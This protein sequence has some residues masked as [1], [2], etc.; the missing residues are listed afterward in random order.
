MFL[1]LPELSLSL[2]PQIPLR[3]PHPWS[4]TACA[5]IFRCLLYLWWLTA[6]LSFLSPSQS[7]FH[8]HVVAAAAVSLLVLLHS[9]RHLHCLIP[10]RWQNTRN[11]R[12]LVR[13]CVKEKGRDSPLPF[14]RSEVLCLGVW[15]VPAVTSCKEWRGFLLCRR[16]RGLWGEILPLDRVSKSRQQARFQRSPSPAMSLLLKQSSWTKPWAS[17]SCR[18]TL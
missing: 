15:G 1:P 8:S 9:K 11:V 16:V 12:A 18:C 4:H 17:P 14:P 3:R 7:V 2:G 6:S 10:V 13:V 5:Q